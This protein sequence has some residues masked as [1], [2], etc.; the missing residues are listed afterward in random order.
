MRRELLRLLAELDY[1]PVHDA[2]RAAAFGSSK[3][4]RNADFDHGQVGRAPKED[5]SRR[6]AL[7][8]CGN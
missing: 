6:L 2:L 8:A 4:E 1:S 3:T 5:R 7:V